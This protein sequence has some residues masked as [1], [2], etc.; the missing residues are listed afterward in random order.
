VVFFLLFTTKRWDIFWIKKKLTTDDFDETTKTL[1]GVNPFFF[2]NNTI[3]PGA[4]SASNNRREKFHVSAMSVKKNTLKNYEGMVL[5]RPDVEDSIKQVQLDKLR[6]LV[7]RDEGS[8]FE[9]TE[10][11]LQNNMYNIKGYPDAYQ[12]QLDISC[13]PAT[14]KEMESVMAKPEIGEE[15]VFLRSTFFRLNR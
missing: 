2:P 12:V 5:L 11:G 15:E 7:A 10:R 3:E 9:V 1:F 4:S 6:T 14:I 13:M 8:S